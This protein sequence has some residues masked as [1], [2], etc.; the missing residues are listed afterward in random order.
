MRKLDIARMRKSLSLALIIGAAYFIPLWV[1]KIPWLGI[2]ESI[3][4]LNWLLGW[5]AIA[6]TLIGVLVTVLIG[7]GIVKYVH[8]LFPKQA[9][10]TSF[11]ESHETQEGERMQETRYLD[12][13]E[14]AIKAIRKNAK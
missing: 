6:L 8:W 5:L 12:T 7:Y 14:I 2:N 1:S 4:F 13:H 9:D 10:H 11:T 3:Q